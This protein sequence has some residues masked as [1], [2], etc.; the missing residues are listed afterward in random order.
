MVY[1]RLGVKDSNGSDNIKS[2]G[3]IL[4]FFFSDR[5]DYHFIFCSFTHSAKLILDVKRVKVL[6]TGWCKSIY[7]YIYIYQLI[8]ER[9]R[10]CCAGVVIWTF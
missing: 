5:R 7:R 3:F 6:L 8:K 10:L 4:F 1:L 2:Q 9:Y